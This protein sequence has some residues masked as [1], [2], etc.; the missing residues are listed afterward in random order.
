MERVK[1]IAY[2]A[3]ESSKHVVQGTA[4]AMY[5][6]ASG[7]VSTVR[8]LAEGV[9]MGATYVVLVPFLAYIIW[10]CSEGKR[11]RH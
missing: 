4:T 1:N 7:G 5:G 11:A 9:V 8:G 10:K 3:A 6:V 2:S